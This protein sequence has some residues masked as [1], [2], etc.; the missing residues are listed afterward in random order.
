MENHLLFIH[1]NAAIR[2]FHTTFRKRNSA[3]RGF[4]LKI[5]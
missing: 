5:Q 2:F 1:A 4:N 3:L